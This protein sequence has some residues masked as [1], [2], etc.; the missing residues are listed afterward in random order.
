M[1]WD[2]ISFLICHFKSKNKIILKFSWHY[3]KYFII[4]KIAPKYKMHFPTKIFKPLSLYL[5]HPCPIHRTYSIDKTKAGD[6]SGNWKFTKHRRYLQI[7]EEIKVHITQMH[8]PRS[9]MCVC[10]HARIGAH[11]RSGVGG[12]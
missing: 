11:V 8:Q 7:R 5:H 12:Q 3:Y 6:N 10:V 4:H 9:R 2:L 1:K